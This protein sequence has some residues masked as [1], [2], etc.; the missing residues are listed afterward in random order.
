MSLVIL[1]LQFY[2]S[3]KMTNYV[4]HS[5]FDPVTLIQDVQMESLRDFWSKEK[6]LTS[7]FP[8][9]STCKDITPKTK[10]PI[11]IIVVINYISASCAWRTLKN[12]HRTTIGNGNPRKPENLRQLELSLQVRQKI[13]PSVIDRKHLNL[14]WLS[15]YSKEMLSNSKS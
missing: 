3:K 12:T 10:A 15:Q 1:Y 5:F 4:S 11:Q 9:C 7:A 14:I 8:S 13:W 6:S 2:P